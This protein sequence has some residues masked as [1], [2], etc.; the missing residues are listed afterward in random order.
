M[1]VFYLQGKI[2]GEWWSPRRGKGL[3]RRIGFLERASFRV[4]VAAGTASTAALKVEAMAEEGLAQLRRGARHP[5]RHV[6]DAKL[7]SCDESNRVVTASRKRHAERH[8][9]SH[10]TPIMSSDNYHEIRTP[11]MTQDANDAIRKTDPVMSTSGD[12]NASGGLG[13][14]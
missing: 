2:C 8:Q 14:F 12:N 4:T 6:T 1:S 5:L 7:L 3:R 13:A 10:Q 9:L 11:I